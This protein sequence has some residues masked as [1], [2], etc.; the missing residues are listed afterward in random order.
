M[1]TSLGLAIFFAS[2][3]ITPLSFGQSSDH[4][5]MAGPEW[6]DGSLLLMTGREIKGLVKYND[7]TDIVSIENGRESRSYTARHVK[8]FEYY[9]EIEKKQRIFYSVE[10]DDRFYKVKRPVFFE[11]L[12]ELETFAVLSKISPIHLEKKEY[13]TPAIF[14]PVNGAFTGGRYYG[15]PSTISFTERIYFLGKEGELRP[16]L[17]ITEKEIDGLFF[18]RTINKNK[19]LDQEVLRRFTGAK[20]KD[21]L[22]YATGNDLHLDVKQD[23]ITALTFYSALRQ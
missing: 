16:Y 10:I 21:I 4:G 2:L 6:F 23:L 18:D 7:K 1:K 19:I 14:N 11:I 5:I 13:A 3:I 9:D 15:Y 20:Y 12:M 22:Q 17:E 8:A